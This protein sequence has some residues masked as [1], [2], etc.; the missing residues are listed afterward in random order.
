[1]SKIK[2][3]NITALASSDEKDCERLMMQAYKGWHLSQV[4]IP[5]FSYELKQGESLEKSYL[6]DYQENFDDAYR[7]TYK[8]KGWTH[9]FSFKNLHYFEG[10]LATIKSYSDIEGKY[11]LYKRLSNRLTLALIVSMIVNI[12]MFFAFSWLTKQTE[13]NR[14]LITLIFGGGL[15]LVMI[16]VMLAYATYSYMARAKNVKKHIK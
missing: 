11:N 8:Q 6:I 5:Y 4:K 14:G 16:N 9:L 2:T 1:M 10:P 12:S 3:F 7:R 13:P 15:M